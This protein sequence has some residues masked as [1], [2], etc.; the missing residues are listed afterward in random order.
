[1]AFS[2]L[3]PAAWIFRLCVAGAAICRPGRET[4][5][6]DRSQSSLRLCQR[7]NAQGDLLSDLFFHTLTHSHTVVMMMSLING[8]IVCI[9]TAHTPTL[10]TLTYT[11]TH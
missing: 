11:L 6:D 2:S 1:M 5:G 10:Y 9:G 3:P 4:L 7:S 8:R